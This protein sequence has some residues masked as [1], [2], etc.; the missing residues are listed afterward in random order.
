M[1]ADPATQESLKKLGIEPMP[2][3]PGEMDELVKRET[4]ANLEL[5]KAAGR[6]QT[7][8]GGLRWR[9]V[10]AGAGARYRWGEHLLLPIPEI[11]S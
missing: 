10:E 6:D 9:R 1:L 4:A 7:V 5:I 11:P 2:M 3:T 8:G